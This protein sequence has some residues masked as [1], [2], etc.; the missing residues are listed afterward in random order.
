M[1]ILRRWF[2]NSFISFFTFSNSCE[3]K[4]SNFTSKNVMNTFRVLL[5]LILRN[6]I[7]SVA[8]HWVIDIKTI[9]D[10]IILYFKIVNVWGN[11]LW[12]QFYLCSVLQVF[13]LKKTIYVYP[14]S[15]YL[16]ESLNLYLDLRI[17]F[18]S[19]NKYT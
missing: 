8:G 10:Q 2:Q 16:L 18:F 5:F 4:F 15:C 19:G 9:F 7:Y 13:N 14:F 1:F 12:P 17:F 3:E 6:F 11:K